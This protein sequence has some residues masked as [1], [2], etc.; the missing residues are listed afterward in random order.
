MDVLFGSIF[1][2]VEVKEKFQNFCPQVG[3]NLRVRPGKGNSIR[4]SSMLG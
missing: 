3:Y 2:S 4:P 1:T